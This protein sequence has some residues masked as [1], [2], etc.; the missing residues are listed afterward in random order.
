[1]KLDINRIYFITN[2][3]NFHTVYCETCCNP[4]RDYKFSYL[5]YTTGCVPVMTVQP[6][7]IPFIF[8][9]KS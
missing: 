6:S 2:T 7:F 1:M 8:I 3:N 5:V 4:S 9:H